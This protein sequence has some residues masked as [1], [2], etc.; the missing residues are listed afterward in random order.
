MTTTAKILNKP[1]ATAIRREPRRCAPCPWALLMF[2]CQQLQKFLNAVMHR[3][4]TNMWVCM[5]IIMVLLWWCNISELN[6]YSSYF[7]NLETEVLQLLKLLKKS[8]LMLPTSFFCLLSI[9][10]WHFCGNFY[11]KINSVVFKSSSYVEL[12]PAVKFSIIFFSF[13]KHAQLI[14]KWLCFKMSGMTY[15]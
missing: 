10:K 1:T 5:D 15:I 6:H 13:L 4:R 8:F 14:K 11:N 12:F 7:T 2:H 3:C 9:L